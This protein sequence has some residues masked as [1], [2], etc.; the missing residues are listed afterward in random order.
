MDAAVA[1]AFALAVTLPAAGNIGGGGFLVHRAA[2]GSDA[3]YDFRE[4]AP[5]AASPE[6]F[7]SGG[8]YDWARHHDSHLAVGVPGTVAGLHR[9][10]SDHGRLPWRRLV[11]PAVSLARD[12]FVLTHARAASL[13]GV[14]PRM[15]RYPAAVAAFSNEGEPY[16]AGDRFRQPDL[17][18]TLELIAAAGPDGFYRGR[19][20]ALLAREM[21][22]HGGLITEADLAAYEPRVR[23]PVRGALPRLRDRVHAAAQLRRDHPGPDAERAGGLRPAGRRLRLRPQRPPHRRGDAARLRG[24]GPAPRGPRLQLRHAGCCG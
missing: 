11:E 5:A 24:P 4:T 22:D 9:A 20:A 13:A 14:L 15:A 1:T 3:A 12:G 2:D 21:A 18:A 8:A 7:L 10:W 19:T 6:M 16:A 23:E 17:A